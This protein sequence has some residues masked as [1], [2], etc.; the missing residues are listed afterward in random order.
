MATAVPRQFEIARAAAS[1]A[2][3][4]KTKLANELLKRTRAMI[5]Q[6][7]SSAFQRIVDD[8]RIPLRAETIVSYISVAQH[9]GIIDDSLKVTGPL[10]EKTLLKG[11]SNYL[12]D[13]LGV[14]SSQ[15]GFGVDQ[16]RDFLSKSLSKRPF[17]IETVTPSLFFSHLNPNVSEFTY[18]QC[19]TMFDELGSDRFRVRSVRILLHKDIIWGGG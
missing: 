7:Q 1:G 19:L 14:F 17:P 2:F 3:S 9:V 5:S 4:T 11:F 13:C 18:N 15:N 12:R 8:Q 6:N 16:I 10:T